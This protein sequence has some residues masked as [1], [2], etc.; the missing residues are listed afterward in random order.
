MLIWS[1]ITKLDICQFL[2]QKDT[3][4]SS[5]LLSDIMGDKYIRKHFLYAKRNL[6]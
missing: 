4:E 1:P 6:K 2:N 3:I 5:S